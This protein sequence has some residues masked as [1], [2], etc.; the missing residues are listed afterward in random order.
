MAGVSDRER[1]MAVMIIAILVV[2][3]HVY[4][5]KKLVDSFDK[6]K[7]ELRVLEQRAQAIVSGSSIEGSIKE[8]K[9]W[10]QGHEPQPQTYEDVQTELQSFLMSAGERAGLSPFSQ[11]LIP[12]KN[13]EEDLVS[14]YNRVRIQ[15]SAQG[16]QEK[17]FQW[18]VSIHQPDQFRAITYLKI[19]ANQKVE[20]EVI[21]HIIAEQ[22]LV[23]KI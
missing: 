23:P 8:E 16:D 19:E 11:Q 12:N 21:C 20:G 10:L 7:V 4:G 9:Q 5:S 2:F 22:W 15:I 13:L 3:V 1:K 6:K 17:I 14:H 18:L